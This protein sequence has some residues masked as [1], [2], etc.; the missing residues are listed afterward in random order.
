VGLRSG[1]AF[2]LGRGSFD[3]A[4]L[5]RGAAAS[6]PIAGQDYRHSPITPS[7]YAAAH[8]FKGW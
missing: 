7:G 4:A 6:D 5:R 8:R 2:H 3:S 1:A